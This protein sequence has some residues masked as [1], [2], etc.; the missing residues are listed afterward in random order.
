MNLLFR[1][2]YLYMLMVLVISLLLTG[3]VTAMIF[4]TRHE[5]LVRNV[6]RNQVVFVGRELA[7]TQRR[8][9]NSLPER[10]QELGDDL[11]WNIA[12]WEQ[13][14]LLHSTLP[15]PP[16][17]PQDLNERLRKENYVLS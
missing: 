13:G 11:G 4:N 8:A 14:Q 15:N 17:P 1:K 5:G 6:I 3:L 9:P 7:K 16:L 2:L 12:L 10:M